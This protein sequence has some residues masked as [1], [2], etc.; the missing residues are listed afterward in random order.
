M[1]I[2]NRLIYLDSCIIIY[3]VEEHPTFAPVI[4]T[5]LARQPQAI[6][7]FS[8]LSE[9]ECLVMPLRQNKQLLLDKFRDWFN[10]QKARFDRAHHS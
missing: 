10:R 3:L 6:L 2:T 5:H 4:E 8:S 9:M 7:A 1:G